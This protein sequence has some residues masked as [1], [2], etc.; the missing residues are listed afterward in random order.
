MSAC[1]IAPSRSQ[2]ENPVIR[3]AL[4]LLARW[5]SLILLLCR[6][7]SL[8]RRVHS[9]TDTT[10][11]EP[12]TKDPSVNNNDTLPLHTELLPHT[13][14]HCENIFIDIV[15]EPHDLISC[16]LEYSSV[17]ELLAASQQCLFIRL[18]IAPWD[19]F[20]LASQGHEMYNITS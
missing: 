6:F 10:S 8:P 16:V 11:F 13:C 12:T 17:G 14:F 19:D 7:P 1:F 20:Q 2:D 5:S 3:M 9:M 18:T 15:T 4:R